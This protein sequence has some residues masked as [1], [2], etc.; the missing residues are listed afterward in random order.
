MNNNL[1][2]F[3]KGLLLCALSFLLYVQ[4]LSAASSQH[5]S[6]RLSGHVPTKPINK[7]EFLKPMDADEHVSMT[8]VLPLRNQAELEALVKKCMIQ[9]IMNIMGNI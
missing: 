5:H 9:M 7:A 3:F 1:R 6:V 8:F 2:S 4:N